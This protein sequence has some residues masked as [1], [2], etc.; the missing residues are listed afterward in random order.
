M[1]DDLVFDSDR[2]AGLSPSGKA[3]LCRVFARRAQ[4]FA[5]VAS[6]PDIGAAYEM[7]AAQWLA[8]AEEIE[9]FWSLGGSPMLQ[10]PIS[11]APCG[12]WLPYSERERR[13]RSCS[14]PP[15]SRGAHRRITAGDRARASRAPRRTPSPHLGPNGPRLAPQHD[16][17]ER[18]GRLFAHP[19]YPIHI[20]DS[21][22]VRSG[23][24]RSPAGESQR[25]I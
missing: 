15:P 13:R 5:A 8:L 23:A 4:S 3:N 6:T 14:D 7:I 24:L 9:T 12:R 20:T 11:R 16:F 18:D 1:S 17:P 10:A 2:F 25:V 22:R 19:G 21:L